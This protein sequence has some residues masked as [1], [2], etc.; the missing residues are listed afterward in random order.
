MSSLYTRDL[1]A[2]LRVAIENK[3]FSLVL[4]LVNNGADYMCTFGGHMEPE[5]AYRWAE[6]S[7][8]TPEIRE[9][10]YGL[11]ENIVSQW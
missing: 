3:D 2:E 6:I 1:E 9:Y 11:Y 7:R 4:E 10:L 8:S 5:P